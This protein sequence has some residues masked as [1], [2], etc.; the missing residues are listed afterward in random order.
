MYHQ[1]L[2][3]RRLVTL[4]LGIDAEAAAA[5]K[6]AGCAC[7]GTLHRADY[8]RKARGAADGESAS[9]LVRYSFCCAEE[10]C[11]KRRTP[12]SVRFLGRR[13]YVSVAVMVAAAAEGGV[14]ARRVKLLGELLGESVDRRTVE[15][16]VQWWRQTLPESRFWRGLRGKLLGVVAPLRLPLSLMEKVDA[17]GARERA[18]G[19]LKLLAPITTGHGI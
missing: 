14:S 10:G 1:L 2:S 16:W 19:V 13:V 3:D 11:R 8:R 9:Y 7:G 6:A 17:E 18:V 4:L 12:E 5:A 15:R